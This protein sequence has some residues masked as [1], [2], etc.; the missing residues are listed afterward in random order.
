MLQRC[1][2]W[3]L[4]DGV[5]A[6]CSVVRQRSV[7]CSQMVNSW[8]RSLWKSGWS[9]NFDLVVSRLSSDPATRLH[10]ELVFR[11]VASS[12]NW[13][14]FFSNNSNIVIIYTVNVW[15]EFVNVVLL[16]LIPKFPWVP[17]ELHRHRQNSWEWEREWEWLTGNWTEMGIVV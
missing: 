16:N 8:L 10:I 1:R 17:W 12:E 6:R 2:S 15:Y 7:Q 3:L 4:S 9:L 5:S 14:K 11:F 13:R